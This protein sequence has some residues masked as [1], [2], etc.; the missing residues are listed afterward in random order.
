MPA[1]GALTVEEALVV[2][3]TPAGGVWAAERVST[4]VSGRGW[5]LAEEEGGVLPTTEQTQ[6]VMPAFHQCICFI[7][8]HLISGRAICAFQS[9]WNYCPQKVIEILQLNSFQSHLVAIQKRQLLGKIKQK[10]QNQEKLS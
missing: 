1:D 7:I 10:V 9:T 4:G 2:A 5:V 8:F 3:V 6:L